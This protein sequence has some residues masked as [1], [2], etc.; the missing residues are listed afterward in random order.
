MSDNGSNVN[1]HSDDKSEPLT[2]KWEDFVAKKK[3]ATHCETCAQPLPSNGHSPY[4][5]DP[6]SVEETVEEST[7]FGIARSKVR[8]AWSFLATHTPKPI[9]WMF[10]SVAWILVG[11][12]VAGVFL[13]ASYFLVRYLVWYLLIALGKWLL[14]KIGGKLPHM[15]GGM[16]GEAVNGT[17]AE[18]D[19]NYWMT[20]ALAV[21]GAVAL[22]HIGKGAI[23]LI[24][25]WKETR[26]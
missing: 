20:G 19:W 21:A 11:T 14:D 18:A 16:I 22:N 3:A 6:A 5:D 23:H 15:V 7:P 8:E 10:K 4:R 13:G 25:T 26:Q 24:K 2:S 1:G 17:P 9:R 12:A